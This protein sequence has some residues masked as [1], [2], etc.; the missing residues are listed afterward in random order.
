MPIDPLSTDT[1]SLAQAA[2]ELPS[3][4]DGR[5]VHP[6]T[7]WRW[8]SRGCRGVRLPIVRIGG[9]ACTSRMA[10]RQF[11][12]DVEAARRPAAPAPQTTAAPAELTAADRAGEELAALLGPSRE[13]R[14]HE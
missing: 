4:R 13:G 3:L 10:L 5:P 8:A 9:T 6:A 12:A 7:L 14:R 11:L 1:I 2:R